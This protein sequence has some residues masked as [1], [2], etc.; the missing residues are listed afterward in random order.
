MVIE[1]FFAVQGVDARIPLAETI[2]GAR[3]MGRYLAE[4]RIFALNRG[5]LRGRARHRAAAFFVTL[6]ISGDGRYIAYPKVI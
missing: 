1:S 4:Q 5:R 6:I 2:G 3:E